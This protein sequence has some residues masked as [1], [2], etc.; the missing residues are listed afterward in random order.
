MLLKEGNS[1]PR[2]TCFNQDC[3]SKKFTHFHCDFEISVFIG[4]DGI[5]LNIS[6]TIHIL[7]SAEEVLVSRENSLKYISHRGIFLW[8]C[9]PGHM[10]QNNNLTIISTI[11]PKKTSKIFCTRL[12]KDRHVVS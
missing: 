5:K 9:L 2:T 1:V 7:I 6:A 10:L 4:I 11:P 12:L 8:A 3:T